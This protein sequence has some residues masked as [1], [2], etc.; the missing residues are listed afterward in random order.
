MERWFGV[1]VHNGVREE[2]QKGPAGKY[3]WRG[4]GQDKGEDMETEI[5]T[6]NFYKDDLSKP[7]HME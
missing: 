1:G 7:G 5:A 3:K 4:G 6:G 2:R